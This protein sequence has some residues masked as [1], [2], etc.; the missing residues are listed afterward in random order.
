MRT[1]IEI[2][3]ALMATAMEL[4]GLP[5]KKAVVEEG[6]RALIWRKRREL[7]LTLPG[8]V[9]WEGDLEEMRRDEFP[10]WPYAGRSGR[11]AAE[12]KAAYDA[13]APSS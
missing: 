1:N 5:T 10:A 12:E 4:S 3:D 2:D 13:G 6:L 11:A 7:M 9:R 8:T